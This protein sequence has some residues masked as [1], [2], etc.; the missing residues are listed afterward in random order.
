VSGKDSCSLRGAGLGSVKIGK[1]LR[2]TGFVSAR[3]ANNIP[4]PVSVPARHDPTESGG[5]ECV[6]AA[7]AARTWPC[8]MKSAAPMWA[9]STAAWMS[10]SAR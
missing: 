10:R 3:I 5:E 1:A 9:C 4:G 8:W 7:F 6:Y 2:G